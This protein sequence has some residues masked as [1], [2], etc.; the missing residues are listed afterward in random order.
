MLNHFLFLA[1]V[2]LTFA[3]GVIKP[4]GTVRPLGYHK[5]FANGYGSDAI[6]D[7]D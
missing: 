2:S 7:P 6:L 4:A 3:R 5:I 1:M